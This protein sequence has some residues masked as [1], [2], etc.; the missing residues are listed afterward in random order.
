[1]LMATKK[2]HVLQVFIALIPQGLDIVA[3]D[4]SQDH[5]GH[6]QLATNDALFPLLMQ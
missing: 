2:I 3:I 5:C 4:T 6:W 1:M